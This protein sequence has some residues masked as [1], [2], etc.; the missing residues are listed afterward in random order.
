MTGE[1]L[2]EV[3]TEEI[4]AAFIEK[5]LFNLESLFKRKMGEF[6]LA[7]G[8]IK[9]LATPRRL[10]LIAER[11]QLRQDDEEQEIPGPP[12][13]AAFDPH[14]K[15]TKAAEGFARAHG[16]A[17]NDLFSKSTAK[18]EI[19]CLRKKIEGRHTIE[20]LTE[21]L[22]SFVSTLPFPKSMRWG[23]S[24]LSFVRPI[25]WIAALLD[26][27]IVPFEI[28]GIQSSNF[29][30]GH[31]FMAP[32]AFTFSDFSEYQT[33]LKQAY[34]IVDPTERRELVRQR[35]VEA[36]EGVT[37]QYI[38]DEELLNENTNLVEYPTTVSGGFDPGF[39]ELPVKVLTTVM[40]KH[41][42][43]FAVTDSSGNLLP[44]FVAVNNT[45]AR[46]LDTVRLGHE[47]VLRAR[48][49]DARFFFK[50]D[51]RIPLAA[52]TEALKSVLFQVKLGTSFEKMERFRQL[53]VSVAQKLAPH[54]EDDVKRCAYLSKADLV[55]QMVGE[56]PE[57]QGV[58]GSVYAI[59]SGENKQ[60]A[61]GI[62][63]HYLPRFAGDTVPSDDVGALVGIADR[64]DT[65]VGCF[66]IGLIPTGA[67]DPYA[68]RRHTLA[69]INIVLEKGYDLDLQELIDQELLLLKDKSERRFE[70]VKSDVLE[71][72]RVRMR[73]LLTDR[74]FS[75]D[76]IEAV[77]SIN[78]GKIHDAFKRVEALEASHRERDFTLLAF[79]V[80]RVINIFKDQTAGL[81]VNENLFRSSEEND[82]FDA[83]QETKK[84]VESAVQRK[85]YQEALSLMFSLR[86]P[87][88]RFFD[89][90]MVMDQDMEIR[91]NRL[92]LMSQLSNMF[93]MIADFS[94]IE[95]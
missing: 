27:R 41:Q 59:F 8:I 69:I 33:K 23:T 94:K 88:D 44:H 20:L 86:E 37:G 45:L 34:V 89:S 19:V 10:V 81:D 47:R 28:D 67:A 85:E 18:G 76:V 54:L 1:F 51:R 93:Q 78:A 65:I 38:P 91:R 95:I 53:A 64:L 55:T 62:E 56:L 16:V 87:I 25:H 36:S 7:H 70:D 73:G 79:P 75:H 57:L 49:E 13:K 58:M 66:S 43:Y 90:V 50:E 30:R 39:L 6:R 77:L 31:R 72:F 68:L 21:F 84:G 2:L 24:A 29:T 9:A 71:F 63:E 3:G 15:P 35:V 14:G 32:S 5:A 46:N 83:F 40:R 92:T 12:K 74:G 52:H 4:P 42:K 48:L 60:V 80:K 26:K 82:L 22:P 61:K 17:V 11:L